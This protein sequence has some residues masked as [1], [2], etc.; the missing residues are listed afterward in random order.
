MRTH[1]W[2]TGPKPLHKRA[3]AVFCCSSFLLHPEGTSPLAF[4]KAIQGGVEHLLMGWYVSLPPIHTIRRT[5]LSRCSISFHTDS[6]SLKK[7]TEFSMGYRRGCKEGP[8]PVR[9]GLNA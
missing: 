5:V 9:E 8:N 7:G 1:D 2:K 6:D 3:S 4:L